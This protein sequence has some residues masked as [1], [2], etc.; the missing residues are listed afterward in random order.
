MRNGEKQAAW[1]AAVFGIVPVVWIALLTAPYLTGGLPEVI[2][3]FPDAINHPFHIR[4]CGDSF[5]AVLIFLLVYGMGIGI[6]VSTRKN[7]RRGEEHGSAAWGNARV[8]NKKYSEK[9]FG[10]NK[11]MTSNVRISYNRDRKSVV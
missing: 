5:R 4:L 7:Y 1:I 2:Q 6:Y 11:I 10:A 9:D 8:V 3:R